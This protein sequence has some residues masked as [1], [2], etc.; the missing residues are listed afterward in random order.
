[1]VHLFH[2]IWTN[3]SGFRLSRSKS[4]GCAA[5]EGCILKPLFAPELWDFCAGLGLNSGG[6]EAAAAGGSGRRESL[7]GAVQLPGRRHHQRQRRRGAVVTAAGTGLPLAPLPS[8][9]S[10]PASRGRG[11]GA[12]REGPWRRQRR[13]G[14]AGVS[15]PL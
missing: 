3:P 9:G 11:S 12:H 13:P 5:L 2:G 10:A 14:A 6:A 1:M 7:H 8:W 15:P 4:P